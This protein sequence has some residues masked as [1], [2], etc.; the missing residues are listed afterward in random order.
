MAGAK[1]I[2]GLLRQADYRAAKAWADSAQAGP[3]T[4]LQPK[5]IA[6]PTRA[7]AASG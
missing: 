4:S 6:L 1:E 5:K 3:I 7:E 2:L